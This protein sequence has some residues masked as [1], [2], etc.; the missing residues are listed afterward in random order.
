MVGNIYNLGNDSINTTKLELVKKISFIMNTSYDIIND[1]T[2]P[3]KRD[4][5][6]SS[7]KLY[8][9]GYLDYGIFQM[10]EVYSK[11]WDELKNPEFANKCRN[12]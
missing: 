10:S 5:E 9:T 12:Y 3:D 7:N 4:Y 8:N 11:I 6:V 1:R 2:D